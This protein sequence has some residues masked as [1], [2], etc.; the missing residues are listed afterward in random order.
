[1]A[2]EAQHSSISDHFQVLSLDG[3]ILFP[4]SGMYTP[5][6]AEFFYAVILPLPVES[7]GVFLRPPYDD[8]LSLRPKA[9]H[10]KLL[11]VAQ[12]TRH[13]GKGAP[14]WASVVLH[15]R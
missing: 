10:A 11:Q 2:Q 8:R 4:P 14:G 7:R 9:C 3:S 1:M 15:R 12:P 5:A 13:S 6:V